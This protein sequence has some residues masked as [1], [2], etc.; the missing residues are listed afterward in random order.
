VGGGRRR[1]ARAQPPG[2]AEPGLAM[3]GAADAP[4]AR[5]A[6]ACH[7]HPAGPRLEVTLASV[8]IAADRLLFSADQTDH[9][10]L[11]LLAKLQIAAS[12]LNVPMLQWL[13]QIDVTV[14]PTW[15][16]SAQAATTAQ[17]SAQGLHAARRGDGGLQ[18]VHRCAGRRLPRLAHQGARQ[19]P[20]RQPGHSSRQAPPAG[21][22][23]HVLTQQM[24]PMSRRLS[25]AGP[26]GAIPHC[27]WRALPGCLD[28]YAF[29]AQYLSLCTVDCRALHRRQMCVSDGC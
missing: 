4:Q 24:K 23:S 1:G 19:S 3:L 5:A 29:R 27:H 2:A 11:I 16:Y 13:L 26:H 20:A 18:R 15:M 25:G 22:V 8:S 12:C 21:V 9:N 17:C 28:I 6:P 7:D 14:L 10:G